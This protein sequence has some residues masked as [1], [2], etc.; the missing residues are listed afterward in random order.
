[1]SIILAP[2]AKLILLFYHVTGS[3]GISIILFSLV[4]RAIMFPVFLMG[5]KSMLAMNGLAEK[6][7]QLQQ[8]YMRDRE[9]YSIELQKLYE[10]E[11]VKPS[12]GCLWSFLPLPF[13]MVLY[14]VIRRPLTYL[15][16][17]TEDQFNAISNL[18]YGDVLNYKNQQLQMAQDIF[19][20]YDKITS[21]I[22]SLQ[23]MEKIDFTFLGLNM[24][25]DPTLMFWK[26]TS[27][28][29]LVGFG[30]FLIPVIS[31]VLSVLTSIVTT[32]L[33]G[34]LMGSEKPMDQ[35]A[36]SMLIMMP[37]MSLWLCFTLPAALGVYWIAN[38]VFAILSEF[39]NYPFLKKHLKKLEV[40]KEKRRE[41]AKER[42]KKEKQAQAEAK[43]KA[44]EEMRRIQMERKLNK[45]LASAS[46]V[47]L[48]TY[49]RGRMYD[50]DRY[51][52]F[53][54]ED[55]NERF[56]KQEAE[57]QR[58]EEERKNKKGKKKGKAVPAEETKVNET[59]ET[60]VEETP[61]ETVEPVETAQAV[62]PAAPAEEAPAQPE[63]ETEAVEEEEA[64]VEESFLEDEE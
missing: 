26:D 29:I 60:P 20:N 5:R 49:A 61:V 48:R 11:G 28:P 56:A 27:T 7:K 17:M 44:A 22:P 52:T 38:S 30:L 43:K 23:G 53:P 59:V 21:T 12:A 55:P 33:N 58:Q 9:K 24:S 1:M 16:G 14:A 15:M 64:F 36:R 34:K 62:E 54:Y 31:A 8:K 32:K 35:S 39:V 41:E 2:F 57:R 51:P 6:Q 4:V 37:L 46:K 19:V 63:V 45:S 42:V 10:E 3:Y 50:P 13:L 25:Q 47:G 18:L 40:E